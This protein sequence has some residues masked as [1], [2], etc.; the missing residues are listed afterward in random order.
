MVVNKVQKKRSRRKG[1]NST[2]VN[3]SARNWDIRH[4]ENVENQ[5]KRKL[6]NL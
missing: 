3:K 4:Q 1:K 5:E 2:I 6:E